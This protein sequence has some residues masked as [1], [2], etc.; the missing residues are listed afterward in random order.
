MQFQFQFGSIDSK[1]AAYYWSAASKFQFQFGS[2]DRGYRI[3]N[4]HDPQLFQFQFGSIDRNVMVLVSKSE[5]SFN[6]S[7]VRLIEVL[8][9]PD[10]I[11]SQRF[12]SS[13]VRLIASFRTYC[14]MNFAVSIPVWF[15]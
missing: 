7:L 11:S 12:N 5:D 8:K 3:G 1:L 10:I 9:W 4:A 14:S 6:S 13:L 2:I 15:D